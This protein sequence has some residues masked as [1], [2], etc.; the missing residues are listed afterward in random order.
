MAGTETLEGKNLI[1]AMKMLKRV[2]KQLDKHNVKYSLDAGTLLGVIREQ[3]LLPWDTDMDLAVSRDQLKKLK[4]ALPRLKLYGY[5]VRI[6]PH[7]KDDPPVCQKD[8]KIVKVRTRK[9]FVRR[10][11]VVLD[12]FIKTK[13]DDKYVWFEGI[14][15]YAKKSMAASHLDELTKIQF[16]NYSYSIPKNA[17]EY[18]TH[19]YGDWKTPV[20]E[21]NNFTDDKALV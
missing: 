7:V 15:R 8:P 1:D 20:K 14:K 5:K 16:D 3:R 18:L 2:A 10:G 12:I 11:A 6:Q 19:R 17:E 13:V 9:H 21:W 4:K